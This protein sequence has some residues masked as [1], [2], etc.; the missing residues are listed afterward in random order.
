MFTIVKTD[1]HI[2]IEKALEVKKFDKKLLDII[3]DMDEALKNTKDPV[4]VGLAAPQVG[5]PFRLFLARP[6]ENIQA[7]VFINPEII[8]KQDIDN[9]L[10]LPDG[11]SPKQPAKRRKRRLL[12]GCLSL[13]NIWGNVKRAKKL[14]LSFQD[15]KGK[16]HTRK[17]TGF[18]ATIIQHETDHL[19]GILFT[20]RVLE[21]NEKLY[22][23]YKNEKGED[24]FEEIKV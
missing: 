1:N 13:P 24:E 23:S 3:H 20:K 8:E 9:T 15:Q 14:A 7:K 19:D 16:K 18:M 22:K 5:I 17:Y 21:Q 12:E 4:G 11:Q 10:I 2:L 6:N